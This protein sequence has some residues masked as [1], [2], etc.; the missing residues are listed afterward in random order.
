MV[1]VS[2]ILHKSATFHSN[3]GITG[4]YTIVHLKKLKIKYTITYSLN[5]YIYIYAYNETN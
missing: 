2:E 4:I 3:R 1:I 5:I